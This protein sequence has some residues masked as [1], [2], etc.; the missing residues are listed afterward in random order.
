ME[1]NSELSRR[2]CLQTLGVGS[3]AALVGCMGGNSSGSNS[4]SDGQV[5]INYLT[6]R[7]GTRQFIQNFIDNFESRHENISVNA[8]FVTKGVSLQERLAQR[9]AAGN[10][11]DIAF[12][13]ATTVYRF[14]VNGDAEP[15]TS[16]SDELGISTP[17]RYQGEAY[18]VPAM[19]QVFS[20]WYRS[21]LYSENPTTRSEWLQDAKRI[22]EETDTSG[23]LALSGETN[24]GAAT[25]TQLAWSSGADIITGEPESMEVVL[26]Q[27]PNRSRMIEGL[28]WYD[29]IHQYSP[30]GSG[31]GWGDSYNSLAQG[32]SAA[33]SGLGS[34]PALT[35]RNNNPNIYGNLAGSFAPHADGLD[36]SEPIWSYA[37]GH[38]IHS[39]AA[40][41][42][43]A[44]TFIREFQGSDKIIDWLLESPMY[45]LPP[46]KGMMDNERF[47]ENEFISKHQNTWEEYRNNWDR[48]TPILKTANNGAAN[49]LGP[50]MYNDKTLGWMLGQ[51]VANDREPGALVDET[52]NRIRALKENN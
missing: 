35:V 28:K 24:I 19:R 20:Y 30:G 34:D 10:P 8:E 27:E 51:L 46:Q 4:N 15:V 14:A 44:K 16:V 17:A 41:P 26:D 13:S 39:A 12:S 47:L 36:G 37:Q 43:E 25:G 11:P 1:S 49:I 33:V 38:W 23:F 32:S 48:F 22:S 50:L 9:I 5:T 18:M 45:L 2:K 29:T 31:Y 21:D 42:D 7:G 40:N 52:A 3:A 6:D